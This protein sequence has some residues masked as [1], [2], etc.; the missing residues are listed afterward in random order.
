MIVTKKINNNAAIC[1]DGNQHEL[2]AFGK[3]IGFPKMPYELSDLSKVD[4]T[5]YNISSQYLP[6]LNDIPE[7]NIEIVTYDDL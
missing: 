2:V 6:M 7:H 4:R 1:L 5:F 3:G